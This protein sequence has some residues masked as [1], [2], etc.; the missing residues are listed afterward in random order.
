MASPTDQILQR[1]LA[2][3]TTLNALLLRMAA[4]LESDKNVK[5][6]GQIKGV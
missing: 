5:V 2:E 3:M 4:A 6:T 1:I